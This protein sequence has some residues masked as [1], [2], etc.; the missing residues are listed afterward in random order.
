MISATIDNPATFID[1]QADMM[2]ST[3]DDATLTFH[4][5]FAEFNT[6]HYHGTNSGRWLE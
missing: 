2:P 1:L 3:K 4:R 6:A 5:R